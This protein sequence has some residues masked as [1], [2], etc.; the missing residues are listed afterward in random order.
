[1]IKWMPTK[2]ERQY[3]LSWKLAMVLT[4]DS[5]RI[6]IGTEDNIKRCLDGQEDTKLIYDETRP[7]GTL[8]LS[9]DTDSAGAW[10]TALSKLMEAQEIIHASMFSKTRYE[11]RAPI[12][13]REAQELLMEKFDSGDPVCQFVATRIWYG[14]WAF[15]EARSP[16]NCDLYL[17]AM[18]NLIRPFSHHR[19]YA[20]EQVRVTSDNS[21]FRHTQALHPNDREQHIYH[22]GNEAEDTCIL[23]GNSLIPL[24][25]FY[26][27]KL[28]KWK[29]YIIRC[30]MCDRLFMADSLRYT[31]CSD[32]CRNLARLDNLDLRKQEKGTAEVDK[33]CINASAHWYNRLCK[34]KCSAEYSEEDIRKYTIAKD[35]FLEEKCKK[36]K[37]HK[38][39]EI[40]YAALRDWLIHQEAEAQ[41]MLESIQRNKD[42]GAPQFQL[43]T[44]GRFK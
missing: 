32:E 36:R 2:E 11:K 6:L 5:E 26:I 10:R 24:E 4:K 27:S 33:I 31:L 38:K 7:F 3:V 19:D 29:K 23:V 34:M 28:E 21:I 13:E 18:Q 17:K 16:V 14:Y 37:A 12:P 15:R 30:K 8:I 20:E 22:F 43:L 44:R 40:S 39:G 25:R 35:Y 42:D 1:M 41:A 9:M